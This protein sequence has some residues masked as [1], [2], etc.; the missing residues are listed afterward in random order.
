M[1]V[2]KGCGG[3]Y[4]DGFKFCPYC[5]RTKPESESLKIQVSVSSEERWETCKICRRIYSESQGAS[6]LASDYSGSGDFWAEAVRPSGNFFAGESPTFHNMSYNMSG[7]Y[8]KEHNG[9]RYAHTFL[10][11]QLVR[12]G[13]EAMG[14]SG[15]WWEIHFRRQ[16]EGNYP[17]A[18]TVWTIVPQKVGVTR[19]YFS[20]QRA[21]LGHNKAPLEYGRS[22]EFKGGM[23]ENTGD[24]TGGLGENVERKRIYES[25]IQKLV[26][27]GF[28]QIDDSTNKTLRS[29]LTEDINKLWYYQVLLKREK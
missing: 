27:A 20:L 26:S 11:N 14:S 9:G 4:D 18:W 8:K 15:E 25:F 29:C 19:F 3:S 24:F 22:V 13:W 21:P 16:A 1:P 12:N 23:F 28:E 6:S 17:K 5:G 2:C 7:S 10:V